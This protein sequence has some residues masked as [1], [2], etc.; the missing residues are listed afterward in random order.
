M[1][2][3]YSDKYRYVFLDGHY[4]ERLLAIIN[5]DSKPEQKI[6]KEF[7]INIIKSWNNKIRSQNWQMK[8]VIP[9]SGYGSTIY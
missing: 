8:L 4:M 1:V 2:A 9:L 3:D 5:D 6:I 7:V